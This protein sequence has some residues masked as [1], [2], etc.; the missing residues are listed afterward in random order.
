VFNVMADS[1]PI[2]E[3]SGAVYPF[4]RASA[5]GYGFGDKTIEGNDDGVCGQVTR[6]GVNV[7]KTICSYA[8]AA[9]SNEMCPQPPRQ[10]EL[11]VVRSNPARV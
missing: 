8:L 5:L 4:V 6:T 11:W 7:M 9:R 3:R 2:M 1:T 10:L